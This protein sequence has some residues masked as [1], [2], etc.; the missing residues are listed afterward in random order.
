MCRPTGGRREPGA[1]GE[2]EP[3]CQLEWPEEANS[4]D[5]D[6]VLGKLTD[7]FQAVPPHL[8]SSSPDHQ[9]EAETL[10][11]GTKLSQEDVRGQEYT[12]S[13]PLGSLLLWLKRRGAIG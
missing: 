4:P 13:S 7:H 5:R 9:G 3:V 8:T 11:R 12:G 1:K 2:T 6:S 10:R